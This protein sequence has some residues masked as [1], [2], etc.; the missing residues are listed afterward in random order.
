MAT[1][2]DWE[3]WSCECRLVVGDTAEL[4]AA[5][6]IVA[7]VMD[8]VAA[9]ASRFDPTS[10]ISRLHPGENTVSP[11]LAE[12]VAVGLDVARQTD[13]AVDPTI[14]GALAALG[15]DRDISRLRPGRVTVAHVPGWRSVRLH[16]QTLSLPRGLVLDLGA[17]AKARTADLAATRIADALG[18]AALVSLGGDIATAGPAADWQV[19]VQDLPTDP[20]HQVT[21]S[22]GAAVATSSTVKRT[23]MD[24]DEAEHHHIVDPVT[25][26]SARSP[27]RSV[28]VVAPTCVRANAASTA[29]LVKGEQGL[30]WLHA[31]GLPARLVGAGGQLVHVNGFPVA[32]VAA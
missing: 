14:G 13:G 12:L 23:W 32:G 21:L 27:W 8:E 30:A 3:Q 17:T 6:A 11:V 22:P 9:A 24:G 29:T 2:V 20:A 15:Y 7:E 10:E 25:G 5:R 16:H 19:T 26:S 31:T 1:H 28:T 4:P 18:T